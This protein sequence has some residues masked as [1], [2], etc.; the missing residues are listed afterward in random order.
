MSLSLKEE[1]N[2]LSF[3][4]LLTEYLNI[5]FWTR[6]FSYDSGPNPGGSIVPLKRGKHMKIVKKRKPQ[7]SDFDLT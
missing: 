4:P 6:I 3:N 5:D 2:R 1:R 7:K